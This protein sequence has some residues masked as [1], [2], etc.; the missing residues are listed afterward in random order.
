MARRRGWAIAA[1]VAAILVIAAAV[2][3]N[4]SRPA[5]PEVAVGPPAAAFAAGPPVA[6]DGQWTMAA[7]NYDSTRYSGLNQINVGNVSG[8]RPALS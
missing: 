7:R 8:L 5:A 6:D 4:R 1:L 2:A 3:L